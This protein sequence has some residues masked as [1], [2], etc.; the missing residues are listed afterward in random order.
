MRILTWL[1]S[2]WWF[3]WQPIGNQG[4]TFVF[5]NMDRSVLFNCL[6]C[7]KRS[8]AFQLLLINMFLFRFFLRNDTNLPDLK[9]KG[10]VTR[11]L[12]NRRCV[13]ADKIANKPQVTENSSTLS[14]MNK[15]V[16]FPER[17][18]QKATLSQKLIARPFST[19]L[20]K[21]KQI[22]AKSTEGLGHG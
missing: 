15:W 12:G 9:L 2:G 3:C 1:L 19:Q 8:R 16:W 18:E 11:P 22:L 6:E 5:I 7:Q 14:A 13:T 17:L 21:N 4:W 10:C 20:T